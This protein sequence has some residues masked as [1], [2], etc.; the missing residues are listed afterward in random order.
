[1]FAF[2][3]LQQISFALYTFRQYILVLSF[4][5]IFTLLLTFTWFKKE[6]HALFSLSINKY[7]MIYV[8]ACHLNYM[9]NNLCLFSSQIKAMQK[10]KRSKH[11]VLLM[12][13]ISLVK[14][15]FSLSP[16]CNFRSFSLC[17]GYFSLDLMAWNCRLGKTNQSNHGQETLFFCLLFFLDVKLDQYTMFAYKAF[18][19]WRYKIKIFKYHLIFF[20][21]VLIC[22]KAFSSNVCPT[23]FFF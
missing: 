22:T 1:M 2:W 19:L 20:S 5:I 23:L 16:P 18:Y 17:Q 15:F 12:I 9:H 14:S 3:H 6:T 4:H 7:C 10:K 11:F 8:Q 21:L 13:I